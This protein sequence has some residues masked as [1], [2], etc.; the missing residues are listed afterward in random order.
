[1]LTIPSSPHRSQAATAAIN[2][3]SDKRSDTWNPPPAAALPLHFSSD[4]A[5]I[6]PAL[7]CNTLSEGGRGYGLRRSVMEVMCRRRSVAQG[8]GG[9]ASDGGAGVP[10]GPCCPYWC[11]VQDTRGH[12]HST[13]VLRCRYGNQ[14]FK[15]LF[16]PRH[17]AT[18]PPQR[19]YECHSPGG[20]SV[21]LQS[22][23]QGSSHCDK[24]LLCQCAAGGCPVTCGSEGVDT[25][26]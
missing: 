17:R 18:A 15:I 3:M 21:D 5:S 6:P 24:A 26:G 22:S 16:A 7:H 4:E 19:E 25:S 20:R 9:G 12:L 2:Q 11:P 23:A 10:V 13:I 1:M 14:D 8:P